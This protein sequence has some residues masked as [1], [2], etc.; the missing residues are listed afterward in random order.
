M[1]D[2]QDPQ[3]P[4]CARFFKNGRYRR[5]HQ[6]QK[7]C[8]AEAEEQIPEN[9]LMTGHTEPLPTSSPQYVLVITDT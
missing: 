3:C 1:D 6:T 7:N 4:G 2:E 9:E 8:Y 5:S